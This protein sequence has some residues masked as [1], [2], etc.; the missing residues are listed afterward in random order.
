MEKEEELSEPLMKPI[1]DGVLN[2]ITEVNEKL[3][4]LFPKRTALL[5]R[6]D[7]EENFKAFLESKELPKLWAKVK[8]RKYEEL[9]KVGFTKEQSLRLVD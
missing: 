1:K 7:F 3:R 8:K 9:R 4:R 5:N 6:M 2:E